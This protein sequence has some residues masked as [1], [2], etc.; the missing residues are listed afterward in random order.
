MGQESGC[1]L[2]RSSAQG[3]VR[4]EQRCQQELRSH[5]SSRMSSQ[6]MWSWEKMHFLVALELIL[7][8]V[9]RREKAT[10]KGFT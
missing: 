3:L 7:F 4:L 1:G 8:K 2:A 10:F 5:L 9:Y 6:C